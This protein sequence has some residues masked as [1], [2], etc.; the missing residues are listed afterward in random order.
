MWQQD[1]SLI[2]SLI[3]SP[4]SGSTPHEPIKEPIK[5]VQDLWEHL[6]ICQVLGI[7]GFS[8]Q[9]LANDA[10]FSTLKIA[11]DIALGAFSSKYE[12]ETIRREKLEPYQD[13][14]NV[15]KRDI[16]CDYIIAREK[17]LKFKDFNDIYAFFLLDVEMSGCF[18]TSRLVCAISSL[19]LYVHRILTNLE[20]SI[21]LSVLNQMKEIDEKKLEE[22]KQE[23]E[24]RKNYRVWEANRKVFLYSENYIEPDLRDN[25][26]PIFKEL[27][28]ELLQQKITQESAEKAYTKY[29]Q[30]FT[31]LTKL[32]VAGSYYQDGVY[33]IF[34]RTNIDPYQYYYR[35]YNSTH[36]LWGNWIKIDLA[37]EAKEISAIIQLGRLYIFWTEVERKEINKLSSGNSR[38]EG[39][40]FKVYVKY[41]YLNENGKWSAPQR[42]YIGYIFI[43]EP[44]IYQKVWGDSTIATDANRDITLKKFQEQVFRK[45]YPIRIDNQPSLILY[46]IWSWSLWNVTT[47]TYKTDSLYTGVTTKRRIPLDGSETNEETQVLELPSYSFE[48]KNNSFPVHLSVSYKLGGQGKEGTLTLYSS[49]SC[50]LG[51]KVKIMVEKDTIEIDKQNPGEN[52]RLVKEMA[53]SNS[54]SSQWDDDET[55]K[56]DI[57]VPVKLMDKSDIIS[58]STHTLDLIK[59]ST[60]TSIKDIKD[61]AS[62]SVR[63]LQEEYENFNESGDQ[64]SY[65]QD[66]SVDFIKKTQLIIQY[67]SY[68]S[69]LHLPY[70]NQSIGL[71]RIIA[72]QL[73]A[74][75]VDELSQLLFVDGL[76]KFLSS[77]TQLL[78]DPISHRQLDFNGPY[79][80][81]YWELFF[82]IP[83]LIANHLNANQKFKEAK[84]W[85]ERIFDPTA[86]ELPD[87]EQPNNRHWRFVKCRNSTIEKMN[88]ILMGEAAEAAIKQY[89][90]DPFNPHAIARLRLTAYPKAIV[91]K[92][93][94]NLLDWGDYL[95]AQDTMESI[96]EATML[97]ILASAILGKRPAKLGKCET[98]TDEN[99]TYEKIGPKIGEDSEFLIA[100]ENRYWVNTLQ[101]TMVKYGLSEMV[102]TGL[103]AASPPSEQESAIAASTSSPVA[104]IFFAQAQF[105]YYV[106][107]Y[108]EML[109]AKARYEVLVKSWEQGGVIHKSP[110]FSIAQQSTLAFC[111]PPN[112][113]LLKY[114]DRVADRLFKIRHCM[115]ISGVRRQL[116]LF[117]PPIEPM[118][119]VRAKAAGLSLED[120]LA[121]MAAPLPPYRFSYLIEKAKQFTQTVQSF[122]SALLSALEKKDVEELTLLR[123]V[124]E[125]NILRMTKEIKKQQIKEAQYQYKATV[126]TKTN[127]QNRIDYYQGLIDGRLTGWEVTQQDSTQNAKFFE[128]LASTQKLVGAILY[129][130]PQL[131]SPFAMKYGGVELGNNAQAV[132]LMLSSLASIEHSNLHYS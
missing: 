26:T 90:A 108:P 125:R 93:I 127:V 121:A 91:M 4:L 10:N 102:N 42:L 15:K 99:L 65:V 83:F 20:Q 100:L 97:Y 78:R 72:I 98:A 16:L 32:R 19:Q 92:Y 62:T 96:N 122:G 34:S 116:A 31:E 123:S 38:L 22:F 61:I 79:G 73:S 14:I 8:L 118:L 71:G 120:I 74:I 112:Y 46:Y 75:L 86:T 39:Y 94:D 130:L 64:T 131:G 48:V 49:T 12:D 76:E 40:V 101:A 11:R 104:D 103:L 69:E 132:G 80:N 45:P 115:N 89:E 44:T 17:D 124:H 66:G 1:K 51:I 28:D 119:L 29:L 58:V 18:R 84:W 85:Y 68:T 33:Y 63:F 13:R 3:T 50:K 55:R 57:D 70:V 53:F 35:T 82:H 2:E 6:K 25:K 128:I 59:N 129:L 113:D 21:K 37:I 54:T 41:S 117:Q 7:N 77:E 52:P 9:K 111:I 56:V 109:Q 95:F 5:V 30:Q 105:Q 47:Q 23:W 87:S 81:Y 36:E 106:T 67:L 107:P 60:F 126:E 110:G 27:E 43:D 114:W 24:W 88:D